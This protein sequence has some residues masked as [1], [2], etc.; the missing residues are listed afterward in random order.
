MRL[1]E[2]LS[3]GEIG[4]SC[5]GGSDPEI[6]SVAVDSRKC[7]S[8]CCFVAVPGPEVDGHEFISAAIDG[9]AVAVVCQDP[10]AVPKQIACTVV[11]DS[12]IA[13]G[14]LA[15]AAVGWPARKLVTVGVTGTNGKTTVA[16]LIRAIL[17]HAGRPAGLVGTISYD[18]GIRTFSPSNTTPGPLQMAELTG[19]MVAAGLGH[20]VMEVSS[21]AL[22]QKRTAGLEFDVGIFT[23][24]TGDHLDYHGSME[25]YLSAKVQLFA[26]LGKS[27]TAVVN[28]DEQA[29][30]A[31]AAATSAAVLWYGL[32]SA[33]DIYARIDQ[34]DATGTSF[35]LVAGKD[36]AAVHT[37]LIG[38]HNVYNCLA[39]SA[40]CIAMGLEIPQIAEALSN[41]GPVP[42]RLERVEIDA[43]FEVFVD[44]AHTDDA[45][46]NVLSSLRPLTKRKLIVVFGCGG[47]RDK[48][49]RPRMGQ[50]AGDLA[51]TVV[52]T[53]DNPRSEK[54][55]TIIDQ[56]A[57]GLT[58]R[59]S[60]EVVIEPDRRQAITKAFTLAGD[61][62]VVLIAGKGHETYQDI[63]GAKQPFDDKA[64][65]REIAGQGGGL[66]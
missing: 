28:R 61:G 53:N 49:K 50:V 17:S 66:L 31:C 65:V 48:T 10:S 58:K 19:E 51:D 63:A 23:N 33:A 38:Q 46:A 20:L 55:A 43:P 3:S 12:R 4:G 6:T 57:A 45:L 40:G 59:S 15:Q 25:N 37:K 62:D 60:L 32:N 26:Q 22:D 52:I 34:V 44:Y 2:L 21:H 8:G 5:F 1:S 47:D 16:H 24:L 7:Q 11:P 29:G 36:K 27:A 42:G 56:I 39:A 41:T 30:Q 64:V 13:A 14:K 54:P 9:G 18:T 35:E